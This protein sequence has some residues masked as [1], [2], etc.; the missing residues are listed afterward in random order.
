MCVVVIAT[1]NE[2]QTIRQVLDGLRD[3]QVIVVDDSSPDGTGQIAREY[4]NVRVISRSG[5]LGI[6]SAYMVGFRHALEHYDSSH[7]VQMDAGM[8]HDPA[9]IP[10]LLAKAQE[11]GARLVIGSRFL[12]TPRL[13]SYRTV[14]SLAAGAMMRL[15]MGIPIYDATSGFRCWARSLLTQVLW[16]YEPKAKGFAFQLETLH[17]ASCLTLGITE[18]PLKYRLTNSS[19]RLPMLLEA[20]RTYAGLWFKR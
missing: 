16:D 15:L 17:R 9:D 12:I 6:A 1:Y 18:I 20:L 7:I 5:K 19:F 4:D 8:T 14:I 13:K 10:R 2:A 11:S 3:Y